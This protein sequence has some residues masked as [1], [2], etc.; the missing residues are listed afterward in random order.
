MLGIRLVF[1]KPYA[2][3]T[4]G[5]LERFHRYLRERFLTE[6]MAVGIASF[7][8]LNDRYVAWV[9]TVANHRV[10]AE[11]NR[12]PI[13]AFRDGHTPRIPTPA[14]VFEAF[15]WSVVRRVAKT[16]S[17]VMEPSRGVD[18]E[19]LRTRCGGVLCPPCATCVM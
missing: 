1:A 15:R 2:P 5:K 8:E 12:T 18:F 19:A 6:A 9:E 3:E 13:E 14:E 10:H 16:F 17:G 4:K 7:E 11:T